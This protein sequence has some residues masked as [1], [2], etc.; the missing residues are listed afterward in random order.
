MMTCDFLRDLS[1]SLFEINIYIYIAAMTE[2][3]TSLEYECIMVPYSSVNTLS[4]IDCPAL[5]IY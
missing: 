1:W 4:Y 5:I 2:T 3:W